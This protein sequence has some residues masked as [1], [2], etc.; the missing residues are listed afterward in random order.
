[1]PIK[2]RKLPN[3]D[4]YRVY[5]TETKTVHSYA[6][7][8]ENAKKQ[9]TLLN[10]IDAGVPLQPLKKV[11]PN[12]QIKQGGAITDIDKTSTGVMRVKL[13]DTAKNFLNDKL[14]PLISNTTI[15]IT[16]SRKNSGVGRSQVF[17]YG[18][19]RGKGFGEFKNN[20]I[21]P[22]L[23]RAL[24]IFGMKIVPDY[25]PFTSIQVNHNYKTK[26]HIDSNNIGLSLAV[27]FGDFTGGELVIGNNSYQT[28]EYPVIFNGALSEHF[29][30]PIKGDRYSLVY[31][32]SAPKKYSDEEVYNLHKKTLSSIK[33]MK[34][35]G[36]IGGSIETDKFEEEGI[37]S[38]PEFRSINIDLPTY[39]YK[40]LPDING[41][42]PPYRYKLVIPIT[43]SR[44]ISSRKKETSLSIKQKPVSKPIISVAEVDDNEKPLLQDFSPEDRRLMEIYYNKVKQ[45]ELKNPNEI[46]KDEYK[47]ISRG[48]PLPCD[49]TPV[50]KQNK[51]VDKSKSRGKPKNKPLPVVLEKEDLISEDMLEKPANKKPKTYKEQ[52]YDGLINI[53]ENGLLGIQNTLDSKVTENDINI[54]TE[55]MD[56]VLKGINKLNED[57][58]KRLTPMYNKVLLKLINAKAGGKK[59]KSSSV[60]KDNTYDL[61]EDIFG[62]PAVINN[63]GKSKEQ[64]LEEI[65]K[66]REERRKELDRKKQQQKSI[67]GKGLKNNISTNNMA[68]KWVQYVK[69]Y[70]SK[71]GI[72]YRDALRDPRCKEGYKK[73][74]AVVKRGRGVVDELGNQ[75]LI[76]I[77]YDDSE[78]GANAGKKYI[79]L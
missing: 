77:A 5:N 35:E 46:D 2:I 74:G 17:G 43:S 50:V 54:L 12:K 76:A 1:M 28:K 23:Y 21:Y 67:V 65:N 10:M 42:P 78:L 29:N 34:G 72:S 33:L 51:V 8:L 61:Y 6:T 37:V 79:S 31:F 7:T 30:R 45:N 40:R 44:N 62:K 55:Q 71:N 47:I 11:A 18:N 49:G 52:N 56:N 20:T 19:I 26:K 59:V 32:V 39:M 70:A 22:E 16:D 13:N 15:R 9:V 38:L 36:L 3:R 58:K 24:L 75:D 53:L 25:I 73:G 4:L 14:I 68:N 48:R 57:D 41:K 64:I 27:S 63:S 60:S 66:E 69:E